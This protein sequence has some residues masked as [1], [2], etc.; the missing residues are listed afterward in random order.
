VETLSDEDKVLIQCAVLMVFLKGSKHTV[1]L[2]RNYFVTGCHLL[3][4]V[5]IVMRR[6]SVYSEAKGKIGTILVQ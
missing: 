6:I 3:I 5:Y 2:K 4:T 1:S